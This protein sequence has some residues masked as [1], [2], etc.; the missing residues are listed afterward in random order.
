MEILLQK[1]DVSVC[2]LESA[3]TKEVEDFLHL[4]YMVYAEE[5][6]WES[7]NNDHIE[8]DHYDNFSDFLVVYHHDTMVAGCRLVLSDKDGH[9][10]MSDVVGIRCESFE[11]SRMI[12]RSRQIT[13]KKISSMYIYQGVIMYAKKKGYNSFYALIKKEYVRI[14]QCLKFID[15]KVQAMIQISKEVNYGNK[16]IFVPVKG[17]VAKMSE[18]VG[19]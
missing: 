19:V 14:L 2:L 8:R 15:M 1:N 9:I 13:G 7:L 10:P 18:I 12:N 5:N 6:H 4:R 16:G 17:D 3:D 11:V